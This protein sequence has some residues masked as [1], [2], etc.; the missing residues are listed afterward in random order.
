MDFSKR[1]ISKRFI[2]SV[3]SILDSTPGLSKKMIAQSLE[4]STTKFSEIL[5]SRM[6]V[7][8]ELAAKFCIIYRV[9]MTWLLT[10]EIASTDVVQEN[11]DLRN[12]GD[13]QT[14]YELHS[15]RQLSEENK[16]LREQ[17]KVLQ[18]VIEDQQ[19]LIDAFKDGRIVINDSS[20]K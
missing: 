11:E 2:E 12:V 15:N 3:G 13:P 17:L 10:G 18:N 14:D 9:D 19:A 20:K 8:T 5:G 7:S 4:I 1:A 6:Q 16:M